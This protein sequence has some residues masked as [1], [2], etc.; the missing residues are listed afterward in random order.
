M[1]YFA[2]SETA[3]VVRAAVEAVA[4]GERVRIR[5][6]PVLEEALAAVA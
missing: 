3:P 4:A 6:Y 1:I 2:A 5:P